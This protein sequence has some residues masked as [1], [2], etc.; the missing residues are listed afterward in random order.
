M[1]KNLQS[2]I[3]DIK[4]NNKYA[5]ELLLDTFSPLLKKYAY[6]LNYEDAI[7]ELSI[8]LIETV[9]NF[10]SRI[11]ED[12]FAVSYICKCM[13]HQ[14]LKL[15]IKNDKIRKEIPTEDNILYSYL[16]Y[17]SKIENKIILEYAIEKALSSKEK[18]IISLKYNSGYS[19]SVIAEKLGIS[20]QTVNKYKNKALR[21]LKKELTDCDI[22]N[23]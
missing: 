6:K 1:C 18:Q 8:F 14:Y 11:I 21:N 2:T 22:F 5:M 7:Y 9:I 3:K 19:D 15:S 13:Y 4:N 17:D 16:S 20:R 23:K 12:K 10:P